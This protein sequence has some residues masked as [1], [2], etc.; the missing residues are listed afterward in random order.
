VVLVLLLWRGA[1]EHSR[2]FMKAA[3]PG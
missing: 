2:S 3:P 1:E